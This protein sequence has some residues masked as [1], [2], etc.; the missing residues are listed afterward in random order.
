MFELYIEIIRAI[1][2]SARLERRIR[3]FNVPIARYRCITLNKVTLIEA[4]R[5]ILRQLCDYAN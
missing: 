3:N 2:V 4:L 5:I 1:C